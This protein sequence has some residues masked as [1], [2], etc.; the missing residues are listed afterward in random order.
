L[1]FVFE[2]C[3]RV[4]WLSCSVAGVI[5]TLVHYFILVGHWSG[6]RLCSELYYLYRWW[7]N[8]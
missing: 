1:Y 6:H 8:R 5:N 7:T 4:C 3:A 2:F